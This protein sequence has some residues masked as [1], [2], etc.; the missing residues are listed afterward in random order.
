M[1]ET[2]PTSLPSV[3]RDNY[4]SAFAAAGTRRTPMASGRVRQTRRFSQNAR[5]QA[6]QWTFTQSQFADFLEFHKSVNRG[7]A[8]FYIDLPFGNGLETVLARFVNGEFKRKINHPY[9]IVSASLEVAS[10][11]YMDQD[12]LEALILIGDID[13]LEAAADR[14]HQVINET[15]P[16]LN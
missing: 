4:D 5:I 11:P 3:G 2:F 16:E 12:T 13:S 8:Y 9:W 1:P 15:L 10:V 14:Y 7:F 6:V